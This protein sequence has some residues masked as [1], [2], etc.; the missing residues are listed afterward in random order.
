MKNDKLVYEAEFLLPKKDF[1]TWS[2]IA[3][4]QFTSN[5]EYWNELK[6]F[7][8]DKPSAL[9]L[10]L[11]EIY[12][13]EDNTKAVNSILANMKNYLSEGEFD[14][15]D[16]GF[17]LVER[18][19]PYCKRRLGLVATIDL[20]TYEF[21][22]K[23]EA[24][25][26]STENTITE[27]I[28]PRLQ[29]RENAPIE[30]THVMLL[31]DDESRSIT[32]KLYENC[33]NYKKLYDFKL[34]MN[35]GYIKGWLIDDIASVNMM[36]STLITPDR[37][38]E[39]Y[40]SKTPF[41]FAVGDGNHSLATAKAHWNKLKDNLTD[42]ER[43]IHPARFA[44][45]EIVNVYDDGIYFEPIYRFVTGVDCSKF[46]EGL[47]KV[48]GNFSIYKNCTE[49]VDN[50][51]EL[52]DSIYAVDDYVKNYVGAKVDYIHGEE[53]LKKLVDE[54]PDGV[55]ILFEKLDK[56]MLF[57]YVAKSGSLPRKTFSM[58]KGIEKRYY[59]EA[60]KITLEN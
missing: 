55:G 43:K 21:S 15:T 50:G 56:S 25:I 45:V 2:V 14:V 6:K 32:E 5:P 36:F 27:R 39:K 51:A 60:K 47:K 9:N 11:P 42:E 26:R 17:I 57:K 34:N 10:I 12:L 41:L 48:N 31:Y 33:N 54:K 53:N 28:P 52:P 37:M 58:G 22:Q 59:I 44:T 13:K 18:S 40:S 24:L 38:T 19:T 49:S 1:E 20:E 16:K 7:V 46:I 8:G 3:C 30:L 35:G 29:V 4:D 23:S